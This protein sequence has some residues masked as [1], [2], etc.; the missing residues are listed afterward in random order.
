MDLCPKCQT[1]TEAER[2]DNKLI[3]KCRNP[4][5]DLYGKIVDEKNIEKEN[6]S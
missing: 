6:E 3:W 5:C 4:R 2:Q 1:A